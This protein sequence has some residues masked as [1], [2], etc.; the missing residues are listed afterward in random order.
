ML[1]R[2]YHNSKQVSVPW[3]IG[4]RC[5]KKVWNLEWRFPEGENDVC[6]LHHLS[7]ASNSALRT[8]GTHIWLGWINMNEQIEIKTV[9][10]SFSP[11]QVVL[12]VP[13]M[14]FTCNLQSKP[15]R[16]LCNCWPYTLTN[17]KWFLSFPWL[18]PVNL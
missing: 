4:S 13:R 8:A 5:P 17:R 10:L 14:S 16:L 18:D 12:P 3:M 15:L 1:C 2:I 9:S 11:G 7:L 6:S